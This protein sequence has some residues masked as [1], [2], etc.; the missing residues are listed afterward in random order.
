ME[1]VELSD[2]DLLL[3]PWRPED[4]EAVFEECQD[5]EIQRWTTVPSPYT[6]ADA[7]EFIGASPDRWAAGT[8]SFACVDTRTDALVGSIGVVEVGEDGDIEIGYWVAASAR[9][10][11]VGTRATRLIASWLLNEIGAPRL[12]WHAVVGNVA[13]R[14]VAESAGFTIEGIARQGMVHRGERVDAWVGSMLPADLT[15]APTTDRVPGWPR[16]P[17]ELRTDRLLLRGFREDDAQSLLDYARDP[18]VMSWDREDT[19]DMDA[20]LRRAR[21]RADWSSGQLAAWAITTPADTEVLG[22]IVLSDVEADGMSAE[23]GYGLLP[24]ARGSGFGAE[25]LRRVTEWAFTETALER[26]YLQHAVENRA[27]CAVATAAGYHLE[28][29]MRRSTRFGD[30]QLHDEHLHARLRGDA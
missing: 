6:R 5:P 29:T 28:G 7:E 23:V 17:V 13:S 12:T 24:G 26:L 10:H 2:G 19:P 25:A 21:I 16:S 15:R 20:A 4:V 8:P 27:S 22:G 14:G 11:R 30:G 3:R 1:P 9:G 18:A